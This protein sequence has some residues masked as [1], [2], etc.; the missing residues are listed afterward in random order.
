MDLVD[1]PPGTGG[2]YQPYIHSICFPVTRP[3][4]MT[5]TLSGFVLYIGPA[6]N[7][8]LQFA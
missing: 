3:G 6:V 2:K 1:K 4:D 5:V 8:G 7:L